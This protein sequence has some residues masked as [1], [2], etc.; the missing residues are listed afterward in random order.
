MAN[1]K[2]AITAGSD[3]RCTDWRVPTS[4]NN[5]NNNGGYVSEPC[6]P[7]QVTSCTTKADNFLIR[8]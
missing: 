7:K 4:V 1:H 5:A 2:V 6:R 3:V 8:F